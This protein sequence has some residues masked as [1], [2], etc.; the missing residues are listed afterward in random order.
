M[1]TLKNLYEIHFTNGNSEG[2]IADN[3]EEAIKIG[4]ELAK[5]FNTE[6]NNVRFKSTFRESKHHRM[7]DGKLVRC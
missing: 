6:L 5:K 1:N 3:L 2:I 7:P 4:K